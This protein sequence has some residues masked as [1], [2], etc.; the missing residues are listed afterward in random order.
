MA[1]LVVVAMVDPH[2]QHQQLKIM[3]ATQ[4]LCSLLQ[5]L[6]V[7][8]RTEKQNSRVLKRAPKRPFF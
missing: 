8:G 4:L 1:H 6:V 5:Q 2:R 3:Q 7:E